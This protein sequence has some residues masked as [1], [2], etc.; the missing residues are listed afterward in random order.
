M[1]IAVFSKINPKQKLFKSPIDPKLCI[2][3][4]KEKDIYI[5]YLLYAEYNIL[6]DSDFKINP[7][8]S[9]LIS[10]YPT[11]IDAYLKYWNLLVKG[12]E[13]DY[14]LALNL[15]ETFWRN[16][17]IINFDNNIYWYFHNYIAYIS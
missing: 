4:V 5:A 15:S 1:I 8:L 17:A 16:S 3:K 9:E 2:K 14:K 6:L 7:I 11:R 13:K 10:K 12:K